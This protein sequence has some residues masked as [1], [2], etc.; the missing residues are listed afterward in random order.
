MNHSLT[1]NNGFFKQIGEPTNSLANLG[2]FLIRSNT[3]KGDPSKSKDISYSIESLEQAL[4]SL[5]QH[6]PIME[7]HLMPNFN[8]GYLYPPTGWVAKLD[9]AALFTHDLLMGEEFFRTITIVEINKAPPD[10]PY[11]R[12]LCLRS[13]P[14]KAPDSNTIGFRD[15]SG[16]GWT[17]ILAP[18][19][20]A[21]GYFTFKDH[22][23]TTNEGVERHLLLCDN[24]LPDETLNQ[25]QNH[26]MMEGLKSQQSL[27]TNLPSD[28]PPKTVEEVFSPSGR[29]STLKEAAKEQNRRLL[30]ILL[31]ALQ[32]QDVR[33][34]GSSLEPHF[35]RM[36]PHEDSLPTNEPY[37]ANRLN[38]DTPNNQ[39][40]LEELLTD[41]LRR[42]PKGAPI[43]PFS[44]DLESGFPLGTYLD[45]LHKLLG[46]DKGLG[47]Q[48][49][50][51]EIK[52]HH[53]WFEFIRQPLT[54]SPLVETTYNTFDHLLDQNIVWRSNNADCQ[55]P[56]GLIK[57]CPLSNGYLVINPSFCLNSPRQPWEIREHLNSHPV[58]DPFEPDEQKPINEDLLKKFFSTTEPPKQLKGSFQRDTELD[59]NP[60]IRSILYPVD[61][62]RI[63]IEPKFV[64]LSPGVQSKPQ[65][66]V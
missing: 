18:R 15:N 42:W 35:E 56:R 37:R 34:V 54:I 46:T 27:L 24:S 50:L 4:I 16:S 64:F 17:P 49:Q 52:E 58:L 23:E 62:H 31:R 59:N 61:L 45:G 21:L 5:F 63:Q 11:L 41:S 10:L 47:A 66:E 48:H 33:P 44:T 9:R 26:L 60:V 36:P 20:N 25:I 53:P 19:G 13:I 7:F 12:D 43:Y 39:V 65:F 14:L 28:D 57:K 22:D 2:R 1:L 40:E 51:A 29:L 30:S 3:K 32:H 8:F 38:H 55:S 6:N